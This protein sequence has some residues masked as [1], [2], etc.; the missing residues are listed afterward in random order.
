MVAE[1]CII[2]F[3]DAAIKQITYSGRRDHGVSDCDAPGSPATI[4]YATE[5]E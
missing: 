1:D 5:E 3:A 4:K 2:L